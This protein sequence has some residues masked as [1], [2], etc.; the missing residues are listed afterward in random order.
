MLSRM[1]WMIAPLTALLPISCASSGSSSASS[2]SANLS[3]LY[4]PPSVT[5]LPGTLYQFAE[6]QITGAG[7]KWFSSYAFRRAIII[8]TK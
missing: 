8:G 6:G 3:A 1:K 4:D 5:M 7:Q 2:L